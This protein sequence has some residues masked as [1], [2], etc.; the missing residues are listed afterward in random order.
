[1]KTDNSCN[2]V[3]TPAGLEARLEALIDRLAGEEKRAAA[4]TRGKRWWASGAAAS[5]AILLAAG[6]YL[7]HPGNTGSPPPL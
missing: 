2:A 4:S 5:V 6:I 3:E 1:M 7:G